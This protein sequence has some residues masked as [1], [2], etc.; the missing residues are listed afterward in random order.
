MTAPFAITAV[1]DVPG[2]ALID[3]SL[4]WPEAAAAEKQGGWRQLKNFCKIFVKELA[5]CGHMVYDS[6]VAGKRVP[7]ANQIGLVE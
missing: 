6:P 3:G 7:A 1:T 2:I 4:S 5:I